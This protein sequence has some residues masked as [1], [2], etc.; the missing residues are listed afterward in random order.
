MYVFLRCGPAKQDCMVVGMWYDGGFILY[1]II[2]Y[3]VIFWLC[4]AA[5]QM[6]PRKKPMGVKKEAESDAEDS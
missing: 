3:H 5:E 2:L 1:Y 6:A 4:S